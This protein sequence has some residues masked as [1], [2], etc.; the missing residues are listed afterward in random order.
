MRGAALMQALA[1]VNR[2][3]RGKQDGLLVGYAP[4]TEN[5]HE[6]LAEYTA[7]RPGHQARRAAT[8]TRRSAKVRD[9]HD[10]ICDDILAGYDWRARA[11]VRSPKRVPERGPRRGQLPARPGDC[12]QPVGA[13]ASRRLAERFRR[14]RRPRSTGSTRSAPAVATSTDLRDDIAFFE[15]VRVWMA[16]FDAEDRRARGLPVPAE[17]ELYLR[18]LTAGVIEAGGVTDIYAAAGIDRP[19]LS[20]LDEA[21]IER[22]RSIQDPN[23]AIEALRRLVEQ[24]DAQGDPAQH[25]P[26]GG[27]LRPAA[28]LMRRYTNQNLTSAQIIAELVAMA[29]EVYADADRGA[30]VRPAADRRRTGLLRRGRGERVR[31][32]RDGRRRTRRHRPRP[33]PVLRRDVTIDWVS[34]DDVGPSSAPPSSGCSPGTATRPTLSEAPSSWFSGRWKPSPRNGHPR[35]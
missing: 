17:V 13:R 31:R 8:S 34:R 15:A 1:R 5:L 14:G 26:A 20:H 16:K 6:A 35:R 3:F 2:T 7:E 21:Y 30:A 27:L 9:L 19:D 24:D 18:Q 33:G 32:R 4:M 11:G 22:M 25:R 10:V 12:R 23:L 28:E 29:K